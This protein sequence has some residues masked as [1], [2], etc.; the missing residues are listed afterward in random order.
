[1]TAAPRIASGPQ[2]A[3]VLLGGLSAAAELLRGDESIIRILV[4][5]LVRLDVARHRIVVE[6][7]HREQ[8]L[9]AAHHR[10]QVLRGAL[11]VALAREDVATWALAELGGRYYAALAALPAL[12][13]LMARGS[14]V[15]IAAALRPLAQALRGDQRDASTVAQVG[16]VAHVGPAPLMPR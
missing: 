11:D 12:E 5:L 2:R 7:H 15:E 9:D 6:L 13:A 3:A 16:T 14:R 10:E 1:M 4:R 8:E